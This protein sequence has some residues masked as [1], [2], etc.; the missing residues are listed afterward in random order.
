MLWWLVLVY[1]SSS[2]F[3]AFASCHIFPAMNMGTHLDFDLLKM[4]GKSQRVFPEWW[5][6]GNLPWYKGKKTTST[7]PSLELHF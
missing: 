6:N 1:E 2:S 3:G 4:L 5:F 7:N